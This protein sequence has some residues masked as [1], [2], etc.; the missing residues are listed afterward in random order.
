VLEI[1]ATKVGQETTLGQT[2]RLIAEAQEQKP[3]I[4]RLLNTYAKFYT[5]I[6]LIMGV[7]LW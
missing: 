4:E 7:A 6:A 2:H 3:H 5:P 1:R